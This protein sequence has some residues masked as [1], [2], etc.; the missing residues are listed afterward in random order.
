MTV[1]LAELLGQ[2]TEDYPDALLADGFEEAIVGT[3]QQFNKTLV[4]YDRDKCI[5]IL[6]RRDGMSREDAEE[7][8]SF[9]VVGSYVGENTPCFLSKMGN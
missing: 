4:C 6:M 5:R 1:A 8:F 7:F 3:V 2:L 9:N